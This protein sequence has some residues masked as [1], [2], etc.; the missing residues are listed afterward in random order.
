MSKTSL[1]L[2]QTTRQSSFFVLLEKKKKKKFLQSSLHL[3]R[4]M[5]QTFHELGTPLHSCKTQQMHTNPTHDQI[6]LSSICDA[7]IDL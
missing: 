4:K 1:C 5:P 2:H 3:L 6:H 7:K